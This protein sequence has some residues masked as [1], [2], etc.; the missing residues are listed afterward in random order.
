MVAKVDD[1]PFCLKFNSDENPDCA[2]AREWYDKILMETEGFVGVPA[3]GQLVEGYLL[4][5][6]KPHGTSMG[7]LPADLF[8]GLLM[9][10][11]LVCGALEGLY[12]KPIIF[13]HGAVSGHQKAGCCVDHAHWHLVPCECDLSGTLSQQFEGGRITDARKL[14]A[15]AQ[16]GLP[17]LFFADD[18]DRMYLFEAPIVPR[19]YFRRWLAAVLGVPEQWD[20]NHYPFY[21][22]I[23]STIKRFQT[24]RGRT[25]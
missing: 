11:Q 7:N 16:S 24:V 20:F 23:R 1:C 5:I 22:N 8:E 4:I 21:G 25:A 15:F 17:Y 2:A 18:S 10:S 12:R 9:F 14:R 19:Q 6:S 13:E 3:L